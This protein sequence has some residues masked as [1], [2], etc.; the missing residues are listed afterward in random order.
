MKP[1]LTRAQ[2]RGGFAS[3]AILNMRSLVS[4][5]VLLLLVGTD[6][7]AAAQQTGSLSGRVRG[8]SGNAV[9][10]ARVELLVGNASVRSTVT[11]VDGAYRI[12]GVAAG[13]Y[14][15]RVSG[16]DYPTVERP[17]TLGASPV[18]FDV[19]LEA[20]T[21]GE[22][23]GTAAPVRTVLESERSLTPGGVSIVE[24]QEVY[25]R[26]VN[27]LAD[28][29][30][31]VP[32]LWAESSA[33]AD[34]FF[35]S[36]RGSNLDAVDYDRNGIKMF[37]DGLPVTS[38]DGNNHNRVVDPLSIQAAVVARGANALSFG[39]ST[40]GGAINFVSPTART[41]APLSVYMNSGGHGPFN[42]RVSLGAAGE[43]V[44]GLVTVEARDWDG[45]RDHS[46][47]R[48]WGVY[49]N[50]GWWVS[51]AVELR[52]FGTYVNSELNLPGALTRAEVESNR[53]QASAVAL[54]GD[55]GKDLET[56]RLAARLAWTP[57]PNGQLLAGISLEKQDLYH[58]IVD[59]VMVDF[60]GPGPLEPVEVFSLLVDTDHR[61]FGSTLRY[62]HRLGPHDLVIGANYS[63]GVVDGGNYRNDGG[64]PNGITDY[65]DKRSENLETFLVDRWRVSDRWTVVLGA[66]YLNTSRDVRT[67]NAG[68]NEVSNPKR[69]YTSFNPRV[70]V[71]AAL[72]SGSEVYGNVSRLFEA[73]T[74]YQMED[75]VEGG[76]ATLE[77]MTGR[78]AEIGLRSAA[79]HSSGARWSWDVALY[80]AQ[81]NDEILSIEDPDAPGNSLSTNV[82]ATIHAGIEA[83][84]SVSFPIGVRHRIDPMVSLTINHFRFDGDPV[85]GDNRLPAAPVYAAR[86]EVMYRNAN[87]LYAGPTFDIIGERYGDFSNTYT[88]SDHQLFGLRAGYGKDK[89]EVF[90]EVRNLLD[91]DYI[92][93]V[94]VLTA[95]D[96]GARILYPGAPRALYVGAR[97][98]Y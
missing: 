18:V 60:D 16:A 80:Y 41:V 23:V 33:G 5:L 56:G 97:F 44:D 62:D 45:Y 31:Y 88:V 19:A 83:L 50:S 55:Y 26:P 43:K 40:L 21:L 35:F 7:T 48:R 90:G 11:G 36:S 87:G 84:T 67:T 53:N 69:R 75:N 61:D 59:R 79:N 63:E 93:T 8:S 37:Q 47:M 85:Y 65:I 66:Q 46:E 3:G 73:P 14:T 95:A 51:D 49:A 20:L 17:V 92:A 86:G 52:L 30:R 1:D 13:T 78:V 9:S 29:L 27:G 76:D 12:D 6:M 81:I 70:G 54:G 32:G 39:S 94:G 2:R 22:L 4:F 15:L 38:A 91:T 24:A 64:R 98:A 72:N 28:L 10:G 57:S 68:T 96:E 71:I 89:W 34:E 74:T 25:R 77:A 82:D 42:G 58:P